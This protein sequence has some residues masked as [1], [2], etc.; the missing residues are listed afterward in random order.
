M[1]GTVN[2]PLAAL[3]SVRERAIGST[4]VVALA[5]ILPPKELALDAS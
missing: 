2:I 4:I 1:G 5:L 3:D